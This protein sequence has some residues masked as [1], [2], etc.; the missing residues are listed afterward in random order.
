MQ[1]LNCRIAML[2]S[3]TSL[4][5]LY[6]VGDGQQLAAN[7]RFP[8]QQPGR[9]RVDEIAFIAAV[10]LAEVVARLGEQVVVGVQQGAVPAEQRLETLH[11][12]RIDRLEFLLQLGQHSGVSA[13]LESV[14]AVRRPVA[15][16]VAV[17]GQRVHGQHVSD[18]TF[19][20]FQCAEVCAAFGRV[21][22]APAVALEIFA[23]SQQ[24]PSL[25][26]S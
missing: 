26:R 15:R 2:T 17:V 22:T 10:Q 23:V 21:G 3:E 9:Q 25:F 24:R 8:L 20:A 12:V 1:T 11:V 7:V 14:G 6:D 16:P 5:G 13:R 19:L 18:G 4:A